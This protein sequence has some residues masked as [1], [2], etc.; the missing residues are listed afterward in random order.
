METATD[1]LTANPIEIVKKRERA[2]S[3][4]DLSLA[5]LN[6]WV[7]EHGH[8]AYRAK[9]VYDGLYKQLVTDFA[10]INVLPK[11]LRDQLSAEL[12]LSAM[13]VVSTLR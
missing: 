10:E 5:E 4:Y 11:A 6:D 3:V 13:T 1:R 12:P 8:P 2:L 7:K 9:Q